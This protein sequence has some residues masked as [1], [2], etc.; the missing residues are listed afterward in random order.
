[1]KTLETQ[2]VFPFRTVLIILA[3]TLLVLVMLS[4]LAYQARF[5]LLGPQIVLH[6]TGTTPTT[7]A[8]VRITG[9]AHNITHMTLNGRPIFTDPSGNFTEKVV[10]APGYNVLTL[11]ARDR[12]GRTEELTHEY[13]QTSMTATLNTPPIY[14]PT[15][16]LTQPDT[17]NLIQ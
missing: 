13:V 10:L 11:V 4:Y 9:T 12:Y 15:A 3:S 2:H 17:Q 16:P 7:K 6:D 5:L 14:R 8:A 1:M